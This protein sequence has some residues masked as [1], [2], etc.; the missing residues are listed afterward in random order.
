M[1]L[2]LIGLD[3][4]I[5][6]YRFKNDKKDKLG[7]EPLPDGSVMA[8]RRV[9]PDDLYAF[10]GR[11]QVKYI[12]INEQVDLELGNDLEVRVK[13]TL[14]DWEKGDIRFDDHGNV[15]GWMIKETWQ[16]EVQNSRDI[17]VVVDIRRNFSGDWSI[18]TEAKYEK[19]D[20]N[21]IKFVLPLK[22]H[23]KTA[24]S[25]ELT[26]RYGLNVNR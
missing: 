10:V 23:E 21:K 8:F 22:P 15:A 17:D 7:N 25:Y 14:M 12:P 16:I 11:T 3:D 18:A 9:T 6:F 13:P 19:V 2:G 4:I 5:R 20:A 24:F 26:T 1:F